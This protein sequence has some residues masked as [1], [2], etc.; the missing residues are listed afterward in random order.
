[1]DDDAD[2]HQRHRRSD[3]LAS[4]GAG[5]LLIGTG[6]RERNPDW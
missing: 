5:R 3:A 4:N 2:R 1:V 6:H